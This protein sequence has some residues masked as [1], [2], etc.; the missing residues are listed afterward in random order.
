MKQ[1]PSK[2]TQQQ[3]QAYLLGDLSPA[4]ALQIEQYASLDPAFASLLEQQRQSIAG[5]V[6]RGATPP[7]PTAK[8]RL[9]QR[10]EI[11]DDGVGRDFPPYLHSK[12]TLEDF[13][14]WI[15]AA[16]A[17]LAASTEDFECIPVGASQ[18]TVTCLAKMC[19]SI[20]EEVHTTEVERVLVVEGHCNFKVGDQIFSFGPGDRYTLPLHTPHSAYTTTDQP[21]IFIVQRTMIGR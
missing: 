5:K 19:S 12:S 16:M 11:L 4:E 17:Q 10:A 3:I 1:L 18:D 15:S 14:P 2:P 13:S 8:D 21:C 20:P 9:F 6:T 7:P